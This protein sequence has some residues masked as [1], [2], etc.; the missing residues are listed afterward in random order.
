MNNAKREPEAGQSLNPLQYAVLAAVFGTAVR[1][2]Q[3]L[4]AKDKEQIEKY[5]QLKKMYDSNEKKSQLE[6]Q[7]QAK[8]LLKHFEQLLM[9]RQSMFCSPFIHH[10][11]RLEIE[12][13]ILSKATTDPIAKEIGME[14]DLKEIFQ[15]DKHCAEKWNSDGRKNGKLMWNKILKWK[16]KKD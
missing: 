8:E 9:V 14:E 12:K 3:K 16:S 10:Q 4:N 13:D 15:R 5:K 11:H 6:R 2:I 1:Y 7:N